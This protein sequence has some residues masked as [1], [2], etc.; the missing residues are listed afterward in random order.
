MTASRSTHL[1]TPQRRTAISFRQ[2]A[3][4]AWRAY[5]K[6][7]NRRAAA[8]YLSSLDD[9]MLQDVGISRSQIESAVRDGRPTLQV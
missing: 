2:I 3:E 5:I 6:W 9:R 1:F 7:Y 4:A 8:Y